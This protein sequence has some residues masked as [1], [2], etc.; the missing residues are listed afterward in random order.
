MLSLNAGWQSVASSS[1]SKLMR[2]GWYLLSFVWS[3]GR[4]DL[5]SG[6]GAIVA[7]ELKSMVLVKPS[8]GDDAVLVA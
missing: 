3:S 2:I 7:S 8:A 5:F 4:R 1:S 6:A